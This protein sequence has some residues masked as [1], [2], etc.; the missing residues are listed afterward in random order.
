[1]AAS[2]NDAAPGNAAEFTVPRSA[3]RPAEP[4]FGTSNASPSATGLR[5]VT[6]HPAFRRT[7]PCQE[8]NLLIPAARQSQT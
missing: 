6:I 5:L 7:S 3:I 8:R 1:M 2:K 4:G